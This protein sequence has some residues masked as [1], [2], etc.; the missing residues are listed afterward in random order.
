MADDFVDEIEPFERRKAP[1]EII[2]RLPRARQLRAQLQRTD[3]DILRM[4]LAVAP[5]DAAGIFQF[6]GAAP[7]ARQAGRGHEAI[8]PGPE[9]VVRAAHPRSAEHT[10]ELQ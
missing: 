4:T 1:D 10:S 3:R 8:E 2:L 7:F 6:L 5:R 9:Q